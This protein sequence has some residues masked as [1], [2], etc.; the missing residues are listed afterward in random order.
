M[1]TAVYMPIGPGDAEIRRAVDVLD[2][3]TAYGRAL[4]W[5]VLVDDGEA[6]RSLKGR[7]A[8]S[9]PW[10]LVVLRNPRNG[11]GD[12]RAGWMCVSTLAALS[13]VR[14]NTDARCVLKLDT[15]SLVIG[16]FDAALDR[17][18]AAYPDAGLFG[19]I[20]D[21]VS[22]NRTYEFMRHNQR[23]FEMA[24]KIDGEWSEL[25]PRQLEGLRS[26]GVTGEP[27][28]RRFRYARAVLE[29]AVGHGY[30]RAE[31]C[32]GGG[33][34]VTRA[35][36]EAMNAAGRFDDPLA[37]R[38]LAIAEDVMMGLQCAAAGLKM[39]D[40]S[41]RDRPFTVEG[42]LPFSPEELAGMNTSVIH[43]LKG[44]RENEFRTFFRQRRA[45]AAL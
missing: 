25:S 7:L 10:E 4:K 17:A 42:P 12:G 33:Y 18:M 32:Q 13:Y 31:Y 34:A 38:D 43:S 3:A 5:V 30:S 45:E 27:E 14:A 26:W 28:Y 9:G 36:L 6:G 1:S 22:E 41:G 11:V 24:M 16:P 23:T 40:L 8:A 29:A 15:D 21:S 37:W 19:V 35:L 44:P 39:Y 2:S 20:G